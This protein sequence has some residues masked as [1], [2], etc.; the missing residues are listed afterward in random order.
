MVFDEEI[1]D[2]LEPMTE[3]LENVRLAALRINLDEIDVSQPMSVDFARC[4]PYRDR[5]RSVRIRIPEHDG[6]PPSIDAMEV[7]VG[8]SVPVGQSD[9]VNVG[10]GNVAQVVL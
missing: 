6:V 8:R 1:V 7:H 5:D 2:Q 10:V 4:V 3:T 9:R